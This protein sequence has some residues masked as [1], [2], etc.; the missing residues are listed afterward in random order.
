ESRAPEPKPSPLPILA[1]SANECDHAL[2]PRRPV[3]AT[4]REEEL[5][6]ARGAE[7]GALNS[8][9]AGNVQRAL[10]RR[11]EVELALAHD[12][13][14]ERLGEGHGDV[15]ADLIAARAD[16]RP[17]HGREGGLEGRGSIRDHTLRQAA[18]AGM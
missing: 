8:D 7:V 17:D 9:R 10:R 14:S 3:V 15:R 6:P 16:P 2:A 11:P 18:P 1:P 12:V 5:G 4:V 13:P